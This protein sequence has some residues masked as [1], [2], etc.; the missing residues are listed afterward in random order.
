MQA[1]KYHKKSLCTINIYFLKNYERSFTE[2]SLFLKQGI[3]MA[4][5][6]KSVWFNYYQCFNSQISIFICDLKTERAHEHLQ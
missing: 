4:D 3:Q 6:Q 1:W 5:T 2:P